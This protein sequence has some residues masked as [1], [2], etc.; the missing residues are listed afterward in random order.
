[1][2]PYPVCVPGALQDLLP[3]HHAARGGGQAF[4]DAELFGGQRDLTPV[5]GHLPGAHVHHERTTPEHPAAG[6]DPPQH[7]PDSGQQLGQAE[8]LDQVVVRPRV[9]GEHPFRLLAPGGH[10]DD[11]HLGP[12]PQLA[13][14]VHTIAIG[15]AQVQQDHV[16]IG[17][18]QRVTAGR[19]VIDR[20]PAAGQ[21]PDELG[22][23]P[24]VVLHHQHAGT[25]LARS[26]GKA[27]RAGR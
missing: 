12:L 7:R 18:V 15:Q 21:P 25:G 24:L 9:E 11:R 4:Q 26:P 27:A 5:Y 14:D 1:M 3:A 10:H 22:G 13:A 8:R 16:G 19:D 20:V 6:V 23:D 17:P 2:G